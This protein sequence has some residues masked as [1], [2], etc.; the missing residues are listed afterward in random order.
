MSLST[1][2][3]GNGCFWCTEAIFQ[4]VKGVHSVQSGY[5]GGFIKNPAYREVCAGTTGHAEAIQIS[6]DPEIVS[7]AELLE[8]FWKTHD[9]TTLNRQGNDIGTQYRSAVF[10]HDSEQQRQAESYKD[11]LDNSG[12]YPDPIV[13]EI[14]KATTFYVAEDHHQNYFNDHGHQ[15]YCRVII[16][17]KVETFR[18]SY[19]DKLKR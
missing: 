17:P 3:F 6:F 12:V 8:I 16:Q 11:Q 5:T 13:T 7:Y 2:T 9:P 19:G 18:Q 14:T 15:P 1:A 10:F 4:Q